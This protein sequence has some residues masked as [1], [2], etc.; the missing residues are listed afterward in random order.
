MHR[1]RVFL[2]VVLAVGCSEREP[3]IEGAG[4]SDDGTGIHCEA[5]CGEVAAC[6]APSGCVERCREERAVARPSAPGTAPCELLRG[7]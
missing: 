2:G 5:Y 6:G 1:S 4:G 3:A 7:L